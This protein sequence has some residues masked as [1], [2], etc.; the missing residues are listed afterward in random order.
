VTGGKVLARRGTDG[1]LNL[2]SLAAPQP[3]SGVTEAP[4]M[5][6]APGRSPDDSSSNSGWIVNAPAIQVTGLEVALIDE[7]VKPA[8]RF[9]LAPVDID[10]KGFSTAPDQTLNLVA[11]F[12]LDTGGTFSLQAS[13][14]P[15]DQSYSA[16]LTLEELNLV[17]LQPYVGSYTQMTL[18]SG[19]LG[20]KLEAEWLPDRYRLA[21]DVHSS[22][23]HAVDDAL[24]EDF[25]KWERIA[26]TDI[27][28]RSRP[29]SL[30]IGAITAR[31][32]YVRLIIAPD[33]TTN[34]A[35]ILTAPG[36][37][38]GPV[39]TVQGT[40][41]DPAGRTTPMAMSIG[42]IR[43]D[44]GSANFADFWITPNY[45]VSLQQLAGTITG[46]SSRR[47]SRARVALNGKID[48]YAPVEI[49]GE[50]NL[51]SASLF[52]DLR[53]K[54]DGVELTSVTPY[55]GRFAGY[56]IEKGKLSVDVRYLVEN[57][58]LEAEQRFIVDQLTLGERVDSPDAV[59]LPLRL[60]VALLK[61]RNG[62]IDLGL[63]VSGSL[64]DPKFRIGP[65]VWK[66]FVNL[67]TGI[68]TSPFKLL[69]GMFGGGEEVN[70][71]DFA[72]G[73]ATLDAAATEKLGALTRALRERPQLALEVPAVWTPDADAA[74][75]AAR[76]L[77]ARL[78]A[79]ARSRQETPGASS[80]PARRFELLLALHRADRKD[81][82]LPPGAQALQAARARDRDP[83]ALA[84]ANAELE[85]ALR[86]GVETLEPELQALAQQRAR[87][88]QDALLSSGEIEPGRVFMLA[89]GAQPAVAE[90]ARIALSLK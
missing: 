83:A 88:I 19:T 37:A 38:P 39:Q 53:V 61:D 16:S 47:D 64:D 60:A 4:D 68:A 85:S 17:A 25:I 35:K 55:S 26:I 1:T 52:T 76:Q 9:T 20:A 54:F 24:R 90:K 14:V 33:Q 80:D 42:R 84:A 43:V 5:A 10:L 2:L 56:R 89:S 13:G 51:L 78:E 8:G 79:I 59:K 86:A 49:A 73:S 7:F 36:T 30:N 66:A 63:P 57:R 44:N 70:L 71:I 82:A 46:L 45:A 12:A 22:R 87:V 23:L 32:P 50:L 58:K 75:L 21:G 48:R 15:A 77:E 81:A 65:I 41:Q 69:G 67:L 72:P 11:G 29:E 34:V 18:L 62:V 40:G 6:R 31:A 28:Y 74:V 27:E 3:A